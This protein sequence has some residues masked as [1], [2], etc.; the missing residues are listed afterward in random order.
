MRSGMRLKQASYIALGGHGQGGGMAFCSGLQGPTCQERL[1][2]V[3][4]I[5]VQV[6]GCQ[7]CVCLPAS[8]VQAG[9]CLVA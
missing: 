3:S 1:A 4:L 9:S 2:C 8:A 6:A 5:S 7:S